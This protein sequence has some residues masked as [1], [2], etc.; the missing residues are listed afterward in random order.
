M[1]ASGLA[2]LTVEAE[3]RSWQLR[4]DDRFLPRPV[5]VQEHQHASRY[6]PSRIPHAP[7]VRLDLRSLILRDCNLNAMVSVDD[8]AIGG[9]AK[10]I[11]RTVTGV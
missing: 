9:V 1:S 4:S 3:D 6:R 5:R 11:R 8:S 2:C 7:Q 10:W